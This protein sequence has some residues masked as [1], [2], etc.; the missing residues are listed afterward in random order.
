[1]RSAYPD[2]FGE[3]SVLGQAGSTR[4]ALLSCVCI[5]SCLWYVCLFFKLLLVSI[6]QVVKA[7]LLCY[8]FV[9]GNEVLLKMD[10]RAVDSP[11]SY[12]VFVIARVYKR[13]RFG[14]IMSSKSVFFRSDPMPFLIPNHP[15]VEVAC[16]KAFCL[17]TL[18]TFF[19]EEQSCMV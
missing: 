8:Y 3:W 19:I 6:E 9:N 11:S 17:F 15:V 10:Y 5:S 2:K 7:A 13:R 14:A 1:M 12:S 18:T 4:N 16:I